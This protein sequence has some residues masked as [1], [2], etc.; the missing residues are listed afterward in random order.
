MIDDVYRAAPLYAAGSSNFAT[1][2]SHRTIEHFHIR[3]S[4]HL[5]ITKLPERP[6]RI[7]VD[8][9]LR[10]VRA[11]I[12]IVEKHIRDPAVRLI[13]SDDVAARRELS[14]LRLRL[15][16][17]L[18]GSRVRIRFLVGGVRLS[19]LFLH[20]NRERCGRSRDFTTLELKCSQQLG[21]R[22]R[23]R[24]ISRKNVSSRA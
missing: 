10:I 12:L 7:V 17:F 5:N 16:L 21:L 19:L 6:T 2:G 9:F 14:R 13:H 23:T 11:P 18:I 1:H 22:A 15:L 20:G 24:I 4:H 3:D 8:C